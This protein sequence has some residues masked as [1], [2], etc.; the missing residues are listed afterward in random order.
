MRI[1]A[2]NCF[3][4]EKES[5]EGDTQNKQIV[6]L[7]SYLFYNSHFLVWEW[8]VIWQVLYIVVDDVVNR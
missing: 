6:Y 1:L 7:I 5:K 2:Y 3:L 8:L 4:F